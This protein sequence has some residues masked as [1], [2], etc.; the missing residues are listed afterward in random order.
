MRAALCALAGVLL[1]GLAVPA[2][3]DPARGRQVAAEKCQPCHGIDGVALIPEAPNIAGQNRAY[4]VKQL[5]AFRAGE[6]QDEK[7]TMAAA[8]LS[9]EEIAAVAD[10]YASISV[11]VMP[12]E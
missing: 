8:L 6:R 1:V 11:V 5:M 4:M 12:P 3:G 2:A 10:W 7:M 9:E